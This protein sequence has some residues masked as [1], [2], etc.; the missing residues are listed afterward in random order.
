MVL[1]VELTRNH[2]FSGQTHAGGEGGGG[3]DWE[4]S[5]GRPLL[6]ELLSWSST[7]NGE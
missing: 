4:P 2:P 3:R 5:I 6:A 1:P 7:V